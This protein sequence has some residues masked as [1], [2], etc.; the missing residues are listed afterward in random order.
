MTTPRQTWT[1]L[2]EHPGA[3]PAT[4]RMV[5]TTPAVRAVIVAVPDA[6]SAPTVARELAA[7]GATLIEL[8][9]G[10]TPADVAA[11]RGAVPD[12]VAVGHVTFAMDS[13]LAAAEHART[14]MS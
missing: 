8:C 3:D 1:Y 13:L 6:A 9:G 7:E 12:H 11:V 10:M 2:F 14:S 5:L 4:D